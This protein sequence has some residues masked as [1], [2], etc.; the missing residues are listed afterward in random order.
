M[1][2]G[3]H[4]VMG[5]LKSPLG[6]MALAALFLLASGHLVLGV[7]AMVPWYDGFGCLVPFDLRSF[8]LGGPS[9]D[10]F[11]L[12]AVCCLVP[13]DLVSLGLGGA[14]LLVAFSFSGCPS[15]VGSFREGAASS[16]VASL[17][18]LWLA[19]FGCCCTLGSCGQA[20]VVSDAVS[21]ASAWP[22]ADESEVVARIRGFFGSL[23]FAASV[24]AW[25]EGEDTMLAFRLHMWLP[26]LSGGSSTTKKKYIYII[27]GNLGPGP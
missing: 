23:F 8:G 7:L 11:C 3:A 10:A 21:R 5:E 15:V 9:H 18:R 22:S 6:M 24:S 4:G 17:P 20:F 25:C 12:E 13:C 26:H 16:L 14:L 1:S 2:W 19:I 27:P